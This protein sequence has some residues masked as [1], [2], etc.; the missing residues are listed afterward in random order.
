MEDDTNTTRNTI[1][2]VAPYYHNPLKEIHYDFIGFVKQI[3]SKII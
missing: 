2:T 3:M 1:I